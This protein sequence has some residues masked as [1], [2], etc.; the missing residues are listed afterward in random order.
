MKKLVVFAAI[1]IIWLIIDLWFINA[2]TKEILV[3][4]Y[5]EDTDKEKKRIAD[6]KA[7]AK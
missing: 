6:E 4:Y 2:D 3:P 1:V 5:L 7:A